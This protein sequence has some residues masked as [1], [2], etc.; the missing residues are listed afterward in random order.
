MKSL[1]TEFHALH[2]NALVSLPLIPFSK[3]VWVWRRHKSTQETTVPIT[4]L[5]DAL[6]LL[7]PVST[8]RVWQ[9]VQLT[10]SRGPR[11][12][13]RIWFLC[14]TC[15]RRVGVLYHKNG[16]PFRCRTCCGLAYPSQYESRNQSYGRQHRM[17]SSW[18]RADCAQRIG[19]T[20]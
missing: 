5:Q 17:M 8:D 20:R 13:K 16:L 10:H 2:I 3:F 14:P 11:G 6:Q 19:E 12:G 4:V 18:E 7:F 15:R 1:V 9:R